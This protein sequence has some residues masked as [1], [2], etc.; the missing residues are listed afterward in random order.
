MEIRAKENGVRVFDY[1]PKEGIIILTKKKKEYRI[2]PL[3]ELNGIRFKVISVTPI[4][5]N[6]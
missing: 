2:K 3:N 6:K 1:D 4:Q 5:Q